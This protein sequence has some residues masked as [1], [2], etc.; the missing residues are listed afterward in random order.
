MTCAARHPRGLGRQRAACP[1]P[2][3]APGCDATPTG[4]V[5]NQIPAPGRRPEHPEAV[6]EKAQR[7]WPNSAA[8]R[9]GRAA[10]RGP[11]WTH[12][13]RGRPGPARV[14]G[15]AFERHHEII[16][17]RLARRDGFLC[18]RRPL[19]AQDGCPVYGTRESRPGAPGPG[20]GTGLSGGPGW[21]SPAALP[22]PGGRCYQSRAAL[23]ERGGGATGAGP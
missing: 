16:R 18:G 21:R 19:R 7:N 20:A 8:P 4:A 23:P 6:S 5:A 3:P 13:G 22:E 17:E 14:P 10:V 9:S 12:L 15:V 2:G 11:R 1:A